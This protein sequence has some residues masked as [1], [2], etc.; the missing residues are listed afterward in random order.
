MP[1]GI[2][3]ERG[4]RGRFGLI[5]SGRCVRGRE[6]DD[7]AVELIEQHGNLLMRIYYDDYND[8]WDHPATNATQQVGQTLTKNIFCYICST[9]ARKI[10]RRG[11]VLE[12]IKKY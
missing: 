10:F 11:Y 5:G 7:E 12:R 9:V 6:P 2:E 1:H 4:I 3:F 8:L